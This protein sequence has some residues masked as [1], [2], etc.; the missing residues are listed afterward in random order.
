[1]QHLLTEDADPTI[2]MILGID[3]KEL[4]RKPGSLASRRYRQ[5]RIHRDK[6]V[7]KINEYL[8]TESNRE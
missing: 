7:P 8:F 3:V 5:F 1:V 2:R 6:G 4:R